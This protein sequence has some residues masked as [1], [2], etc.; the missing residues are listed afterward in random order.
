MKERKCKTK[1]DTETEKGKVDHLAKR[2]GVTP[3]M[4]RLEEAKEKE[5][6]VLTIQGRIYFKIWH[7]E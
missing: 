7:P 6:K 1:E 2:F 5:K 4:A 3:K